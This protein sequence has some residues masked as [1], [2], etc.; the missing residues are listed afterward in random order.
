VSIVTLGVPFLDVDAKSQEVSALRATAR[1]PRRGR[2]RCPRQVVDGSAGEM[3]RGPPGGAGPS[4]Q[5]GRI[6]AAGRRSTQIAG[7]V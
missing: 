1:P 2:F 3:D 6:S 4:F 5:R 7:R